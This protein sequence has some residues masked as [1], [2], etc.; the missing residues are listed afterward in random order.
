MLAAV[1][2]LMMAE[3]SVIAPVL[4]LPVMEKSSIITLLAAP[5]VYRS[6]ITLFTSVSFRIVMLDFSEKK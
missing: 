1:D 2:T 6:S 3:V 5:I 4:V